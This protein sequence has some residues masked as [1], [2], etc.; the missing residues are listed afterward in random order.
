MTRRELIRLWAL[1]TAL[2]AVIVLLAT[3][4][5]YLYLRSPIVALAV[6]VA[7]MSLFILLVLLGIP[8]VAKTPKG[9]DKT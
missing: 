6:F 1:L 3:L 8:W 7:V 9:S 2:V 4:V 5:N